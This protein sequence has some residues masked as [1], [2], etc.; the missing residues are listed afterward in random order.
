MS[1]HYLSTVTAT[2][3]TLGSAGK[4]KAKH[5]LGLIHHRKPLKVSAACE[6]MRHT[7]CFSLN[8]PCGCHKRGA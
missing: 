3:E 8:C 7:A 6:Q 4:N 5:S 1:P 2:R